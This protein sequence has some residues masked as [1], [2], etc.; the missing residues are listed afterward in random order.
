MSD[1]FGLK[2]GIEGEK[3]FKQSIREINDSFKVLGSE[4]KLV[5]SNFDKN[6]RSIE[7]LTA[8][9]KALENQIT[10]QKNKVE[11][12]KSALDNAST[13]FGENDKRTQQWQIQLNNATADLNKMEREVS[14]N[15]EA[16]EQLSLDMLHG[17]DSAEKLSSGMKDS[18]DIAGNSKN[19]FDGLGTTLKGIGIAITGVVVAI[20]ACAIKAGADLMSLGDD[21][22]KAVNQISASTGASGT[23]L[24][25]LGKIAQ[26]VYTNNFGENL[27]DVAN[28]LS[29]V[30]KITGLM[31]DELQ[32]ATESGFAL[33][34]TFGYD[35][36]ES[37]RTANALMKNFGI[38]SKE[39]YDIIA[40]GAQN[41]ADQNGDL[42]DTLNEYS[43]QYSAL[44]LSA[45]QFVSGLIE[46]AEQGVFSIDK[47]GDAVK[48]FN[49]R[50]K[51]GSSTTIEA[52]NA[53]GMNA[54]NMMVS[55]AEGGDVASS[56]FFEVV[57]A[58][59]KMEDP[60]AKNTAAVALLGTQYEDLE[61]TV[62]P[63]LSAMQDEALDTSNALNQI[64]QVKYNDLNSALEG[65][66]RSIQGVFLPAVSEMSSGITS[67]FSSLGN[68]I[69]NANG[70]M[71]KISLALG[72]TMG[73]IA[74][75]IT[76]EMPLFLGVGLDILS[77]I[78]SSIVDNLGIIVDSTVLIIMTVFNG[79][80]SALPQMSEGALQLILALVN[81]IVANLPQIL[82]A[83]VQTILSLV[84]GISEALPTLV[85]TIIQAVTLMCQTLIDN[86]PLI[87]NAALML[88][89]GLAEGLLL[90]LPILIEALPQLIT[91]IID[92]L[93]GSIPQ[94]IE[95]GITLLTSLVSALP[96]IISAIVKAI[97]Q[98]ITTI[99]DG[100]LSN[101]DK[102]IMA[103]VDLFVALITNLPIIIAEII[104][105][106]PLIID[107]IV[108]AFGKLMYKIVDIGGNIVKGLWEGITSLASWLWD[109][110]SGWISGIWDGICDFFGIKSPSREM[111]WIGEMLVEGLAGSIT[112]KGKKAVEATQKMSKGIKDSM[113]GL[114]ADMVNSF[115]SELNTKLNTEMTTGIVNGL[116][117]GI[118]SSLGKNSSQPIILQINLDS[119]V[120][121]QS[122]F[123][124][125]KNVAME[126]GVSFG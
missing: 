39:A 98:I 10:A 32:S 99:T 54:D 59:D 41:G 27:E 70:D 20:G 118:S 104:K 100:L 72:D 93:I 37:A 6:E 83:G 3:D 58:L 64:T 90:A 79:L 60:I 113:S 87:L 103:G 125:L 116:V 12:L 44:G 89:S 78:G 123:D 49:I 55:F 26:N 24:E 30:K 73:E 38:S 46:G 121:A 91:A 28:G 25:N 80:I 92:F 97:P 63:V 14:S 11:T 22:N 96:E 34:D 112:N 57:A 105:A 56:A 107:G 111:A 66:S 68:N 108:D 106:V 40:T 124:P 13:S 84:Q 61:S 47:V 50:A 65:T 1:T 35:L 2:I 45:D 43:A 69:N 71:E 36:Q 48:E 114:S 8:T 16:I 88:V 31:G 29:E 33:R 15:E 81:G 4:M 117:G 109:K 74:S 51:D 95:T 5:T 115:P 86:L 67:A 9:N 110:V 82:N 85:P 19:A 42:L 17:A 122:V 7:S 102:I 119:R 62:L 101:I 53:L 126:R 75:I 120:I 94:I 52:F 77:A 21:Y 18:G 23:E 76:K